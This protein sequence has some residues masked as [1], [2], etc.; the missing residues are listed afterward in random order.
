MTPVLKKEMTSDFSAG[1]SRLPSTR[2]Y[3]HTQEFYPHHNKNK[4]SQ[5]LRK[6]PYTS[7][8]ESQVSDLSVLSVLYDLSVLT[9]LTMLTIMIMMTMMAISTMTTVWNTITIVFV[10]K[11]EAVQ[12][13]G[14]GCLISCNL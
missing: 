10:R 4:T 11:L 1:T 2:T 8:L 3:H 13:Q 14:E 12:K 5:E 7:Y 6:P 9:M